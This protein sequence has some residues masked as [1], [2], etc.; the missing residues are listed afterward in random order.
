MPNIRLSWVVLALLLFQLNTL[1]VGRFVLSK[2][3]K[4]NLATTDPLIRPSVLI[5]LLAEK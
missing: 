5:Q 4:I 2:L 1:L 3:G